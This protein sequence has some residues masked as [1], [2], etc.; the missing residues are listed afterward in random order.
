VEFSFNNYKCLLKGFQQGKAW[1]LEDANNYKIFGQK[2]VIFQLLQSSSA[3]MALTETVQHRSA[4]ELKMLEKL[5]QRYADVFQEP[6]E[7]P[8]HRAHGHSI[9]LQVGIQAVSV[10]PYRYPYY[11]K[12]EIE[13]IVKEL[14]ASGVI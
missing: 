5:L 6:I 4:A 11:Q 10:S 8:P 13:R 9:L 12:E 7:L 1:S 3:K 14:L 2:G